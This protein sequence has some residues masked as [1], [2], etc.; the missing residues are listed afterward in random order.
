[1][2]PGPG[3]W[4]C[5]AHRPSLVDSEPLIGVGRP[6]CLWW[7]ASQTPLLKTRE[8]REAAAARAKHSIY[9]GSASPANAPAYKQLQGAQKAATRLESGAAVPDAK[10]AK[11][12]EL[13]RPPT[14]TEEI[15]ACQ[16]AS[17]GL[18]SSQLAWSR[19]WTFM[20]SGPTEHPA[21]V[22]RGVS[23]AELRQGLWEE[24]AALDRTR[25]SF[26]RRSG[27]RGRKRTAGMAALI[28][29]A[30]K[31]ADTRRTAAG[32]A[33][34]GKEDRL[35]D[36]PEVPDTRGECP[37]P[38]E[39]SAA[40]VR[41]KSLEGMLRVG[42]LFVAPLLGVLERAA[43]GHAQMALPPSFLADVHTALAGETNPR[44]GL[45]LLRCARLAAA[46]VIL[47][48]DADTDVDPTAIPR[49]LGHHT[50]RLVP[51]KP[52][53]AGNDGGALAP[54][55]A[56]APAAATKQQG[57]SRSSISQFVAD[58]PGQTIGGAALGLSAHALDKSELVPL[59]VRM[60]AACNAGL[61]DVAVGRPVAGM[62]AGYFGRAGNGPAFAPA[63]SGSVLFRQDAELG[64]SA[65]VGKDPLRFGVPLVGLAGKSGPGEEESKA[66]G[67]YEGEE[68][69]EEDD[70]L[71]AEDEFGSAAAGGRSGGRPSRRPSSLR[72]AAAMEAR[73]EQQ[74]RDSM[75]A[76][77]LLDTVQRPSSVPGMPLHFLLAVRQEC[78]LAL[79]LL[80]TLPSNAESLLWEDL[81]IDALLPLLVAPA[82]ADPE[83]L[84]PL[85]GEGA[86]S[87]AA[88]TQDQDGDGPASGAGA[89]GDAGEE[90][91]DH[92]DDQLHASEDEDD[93]SGGD[94]RGSGGKGRGEPGDGGEDEQEDEGGLA[95]AR[96]TDVYSALL[97][98]DPDTRLEVSEAA[99]LSAAQAARAACEALIVGV[100]A[101]PRVARSFARED[102]I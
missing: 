83:P 33:W 85:V 96:Q 88:A 29:G 32:R 21:C 35:E 77:W 54:A 97:R 67:S 84:K 55:S 19:L 3:A 82:D 25:R 9:P 42:D 17:V 90:D 37:V 91:H 93:G 16:A 95:G 92:D 26:K 40:A 100:W 76:V 102:R 58:R 45:A 59:L 46:C 18:G 14:C 56:P 87:G 64:G 20:L 7:D 47:D 99:P 51:K 36:K 94:G 48:P 70:P 34:F 4:I 24:E 44:R 78:V 22:W 72:F 68:D 8:Q 53:G 39:H 101:A 62:E 63:G 27:D 28:A 6:G 60:L 73:R 43:Q 12:A 98:I 2:P 52:A 86:S 61:G 49:V 13:L 69:N 79:R 71:T 75:R 30:V 1:M 57:V 11:D 31:E 66:G 38:W 80:L 41:Y 5:D 50:D 10:K 15:M 65:I 81:G 89:G 74:I 23:L